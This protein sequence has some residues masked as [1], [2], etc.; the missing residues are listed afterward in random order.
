MRRLP[1]VLS[2][3]VLLFTVVLASCGGTG[4]PEHESSGPKGN[5]ITREYR[6]GPFCVRLLA[7]KDSLSIAE[8][9][10]L[11]IEAE[12]DEGF[13]AELPK[14]GEKLGEF[15]VRDYRDE[16]PR[17]TPEKKIVSRK[18]Y[19]L[20]PF[21]SG[22]YLISPMPVRFRKQADANAGAEGGSNAGGLWQ[23]EISTEEITIKVNS[24]LE[25]DHQEMAL[26][27]IKG[28]VA[29][30]A[31]P[32][33]LVYLFLGLAVVGLAAGGAFLLLRRKRTARRQQEAPALPAHELA[34]RQL[35]EIL[36]EKLIERGETK[37]FFSKVSDVLRGYIENRFGL[38]A[39]RRTTEE[40]LSDISRDALFSAEHKGLLTAF[41]RDCDLVKFAEHLPSPEEIGK[42][43]NSCRAFI[44]ATRVDREIGRR[45]EG[46]MGGRGEG[47][48]RRRGDRESGR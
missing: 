12:V 37:L 22:D 1:L 10:L 44:D 7:D 20:E 33:P 25:K 26:N 34:Y 9:L 17:L 30:P 48:T 15:G 3:T 39:P 18:V 11:T 5:A 36:D 47:E 6:R 16:P 27:P 29:L 31:K 19:T 23:Q 21:L 2:L 32:I 38:Q 24:L 46:E 13:E 45:G 40:F 41:L 4:K 14:F 8:N 42:A 28:P 35:Q 43:V